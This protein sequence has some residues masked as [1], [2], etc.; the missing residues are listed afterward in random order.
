MRLFN[1]L[2]HTY[3]AEES[4]EPSGGAPAPAATPVGESAPTTTPAATPPVEAKKDDPPATPAVEKPTFSTPAE[5][6]VST[7]LEEAGIDPTK[8]K[9]A[10][11]NNAGLCTPE[12]FKALVEKHGEG[13]ATLLSNQMTQLYKAGVV[14]ANEQDQ[15]VYDQVQEAF[16]GVTEQDGQETWAELNTWAA[17]N[18]SNDDR[19]ELNAIIAK[20]GM[21]AK[22]AVQELVN[23]F[24][25]S[26]SYS[27]EMIGLEG[28]N[29]PNSTQGGDIS[30]KEYNIELDKLL[31]KGHDYETS[32]E[33]KALQARRAR[34]AKRNI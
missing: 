3:M 24:Q 2:G 18:V 25:Q 6:Q 8:A 28:D 14:A 20:G 27:Q 1:M 12:V 9:E 34:S 33:V 15:A 5:K 26:G 22:L 7:M 31:S 11:A 21:G 10:F 13:M 23:M 16:K 19:K 30:R 32:R 17:E 4:G 29:T